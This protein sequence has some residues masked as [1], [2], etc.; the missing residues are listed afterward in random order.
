MLA[1]INVPANAEV[2][3]VA[4]TTETA[5]ADVK[6]ERNSDSGESFHMSYT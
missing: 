6:E 1:K 5:R 2:G 3:L 4:A